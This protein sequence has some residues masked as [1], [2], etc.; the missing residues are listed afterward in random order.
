LPQEGALDDYIRRVV[1]SDNLAVRSQ[2]SLPC[3]VGWMIDSARAVWHLHHSGPHAVVHRD[4]KPPNLLV[5][6][7]RQGEAPVGAGAGAGAGAAA[8]SLDASQVEV[9]GVVG[10]GGAWCFAH[11]AVVIKLGDFGTARSLSATTVVASM[12][13]NLFCQAP[14]VNM[15]GYS[16]AADVFAW[17]VSMCWV[18]MQVC[19]WCEWVVC[20][21]ACA[22]GMSVFGWMWGGRGMVAAWMGECPRSKRPN[23]STLIFYCAPCV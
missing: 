12:A 23:P 15:D 8:G 16:P 10:A 11:R 22:W 19:G 3:V 21:C 6:V 18:V 2:A 13:G 7:R 14:E 9:G 4:L 1:A 5:V 20:M 17:A